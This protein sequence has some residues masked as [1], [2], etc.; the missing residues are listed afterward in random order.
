[1]G[2]NLRSIVTTVGVEGNPNNNT[3]DTLIRPPSDHGTEM[4]RWKSRVEKS[5][6]LSGAPRLTTLIPS[7]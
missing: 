4:P 6:I 3:I 2:N 7:I 5:W 1:M